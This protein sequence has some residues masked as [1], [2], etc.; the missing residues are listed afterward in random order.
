MRIRG[1]TVLPLTLM[2][3]SHTASGADAGIA[4]FSAH[5]QADWKAISVGTSDTQSTGMKGLSRN[6]PEK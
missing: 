4:P 6:G 3:A 5:Y 1:F 2:A